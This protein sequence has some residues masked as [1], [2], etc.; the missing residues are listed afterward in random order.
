MLT[1]IYIYSYN[2]YMT[3]ATAGYCFMHVNW[4][5]KQDLKLL[6]DKECSHLALVTPRCLHIVL[7]AGSG[8]RTHLKNWQIGISSLK[9]LT[10]P[11]ATPVSSTSS[12]SDDFSSSYFGKQDKSPK[13]PTQFTQ[14]IAGLMFVVKANYGIIANLA[15]GT[16]SQRA[17]GCGICQVRIFWDFG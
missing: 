15:D 2:V 17:Q 4:P 11:S 12:S 1:I 16:V 14:S 7:R 10:L 5:P 3:P 13:S 8:N 9:W 6:K